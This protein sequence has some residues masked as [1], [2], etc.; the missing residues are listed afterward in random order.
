[1]IQPLFSVIPP[2][3][4]FHAF[5]ISWFLLSVV[6][7]SS[8]SFFSFSL[9]LFSYFLFFF[10]LHISY[11]ALLSGVSMYFSQAGFMD[12]RTCMH[13]LGKMIR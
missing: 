11:V 4:P 10:F 8:V 2:V 13:G 1:M 3:G 6:I 5:T 9:F 7:Y 12:W